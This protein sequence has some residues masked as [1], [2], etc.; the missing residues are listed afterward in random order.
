MAAVTTTATTLV[1]GDAKV[2]ACATIT[3]V[4]QY[5]HTLTLSA[6]DVIF[7]PMWRIPN[8]AT[9]TSVRI[10]GRTADG[11][12]IIKPVIRVYNSASAATDTVLGSL[13][14]S[15]AGRLGDVVY[16]SAGDSAHL[17]FTHSASDDAAVHFAHLILVADTAASG[18]GS[19]SIDIIVQYTMNK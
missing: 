14:L 17:P 16:S 3:R 19:T 10:G 18:T 13:T 15:V 1:Y 6:T 5:T 4:W 2:D 9:I 8:H 12:N 7:H 11:T